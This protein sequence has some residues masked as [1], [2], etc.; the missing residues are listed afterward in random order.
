[1][2]SWRVPVDAR[3][4]EMFPRPLAGTVE[5]HHFES[6]AL[7]GNP[8]DDPSDRDLPVYLPPSGATRGKPL[9]VLLSGYTGS[10]WENLQRGG[11]LRDSLGGRLDRLIREKAVSE[12]V[13]ISPNCL[14]TLGGSQYLN[15]TATGRYEDYVVDEVV[16]W[17]RRK[18]GSGPTAVLGTSSGGYGAMVLGLRHP[19]MFS[20][21][22]TDAGDAYFEYC[23]PPDFPAAFRELRSAGGPEPFLR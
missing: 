16:P 23:Y 11:F 3:T 9:L 8:W 7:K 14:T 6:R 10:G 15:S 1:M 4:E 13:M 21:L 17:V 19:E 2:P 5:V 18:Y 12:A 20:A 22:G